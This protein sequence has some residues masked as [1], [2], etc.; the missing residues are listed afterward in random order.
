MIKCKKILGRYM[1]DIDYQSE[2][3]YVEYKIINILKNNGLSQKEIDSVIKSFLYDNI[4]CSINFNIA[5]DI[6]NL[7]NSIKSYELKEKVIDFLLKFEFN[8]IKKYKD[9]YLEYEEKIIFNKI[10]ILVHN[11][12]IDLKKPT[13]DGYFILSIEK[14]KNIVVYQENRDY[15]DNIVKDVYDFD[16]YRATST[17]QKREMQ[18]V[19]KR[20]KEILKSY[21]LDIPIDKEKKLPSY[22]YFEIIEELNDLI[23]STKYITNMRYI[24]SIKNSLYPVFEFFNI[25]SPKNSTNKTK[26]K[27]HLSKYLLSM[28]PFVN[29]ALILL[30]TLTI[31]ISVYNLYTYLIGIYGISS[32]I[33]SKGELFDI[34]FSDY[35]SHIF[36]VFVYL[37]ITYSLSIALYTLFFNDK[38]ILYFLF[39][40]IFSSVVINIISNDYLLL[41]LQILLIVILFLE[42]GIRGLI[43]IWVQTIGIVG[44]G[45]LLLLNEY[46][47]GTI[48]FFLYFSVLLFIITKSHNKKSLYLYYIFSL[49]FTFVILFT[50][51]IFNE[52][53]FFYDLLGKNM[54]LFALAILYTLLSFGLLVYINYFTTQK[55]PKHLYSVSFEL[56][57]LFLVL[58]LGYNLA[59]LYIEN[60]DIN[61]KYWIAKYHKMADTY[62]S[63]SQYPSM[64]RLDGVCGYAVGYSGGLWHYYSYEYIQKRLDIYYTND[65]NTTQKFAHHMLVSLDVSH[66]KSK[67][68]VGTQIENLEYTTVKDI[69]NLCQNTIKVREN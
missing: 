16:R 62:T 53:Y 4:K 5:K 55:P 51:S 60:K 13:K 34:V 11:R 19:E 6:L 39:F 37:V 12:N 10:D 20:C 21:D 1:S 14:L 61:S 31:S 26:Q 48:S 68:I 25:S 43:L 9:L 27:Y 24:D 58:L 23:E 18:N 28:S 54:G 29:K 8:P 2:L 7:T 32:D 30:I 67:P 15:L 47:L 3:K 44:A 63:Y 59:I 56:T 65:T 17:L 69:K 66:L 40:M 35:Y 42:I 45:I 36:E 46:I 52:K 57:K 50:I 38:R 33:V 41:I 49:V 64:V 22:Y